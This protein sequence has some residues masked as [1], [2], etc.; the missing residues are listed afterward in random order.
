MKS[1]APV[2]GE[3]LIDQLILVEDED[4]AAPPSLAV[5]TGEHAAQL[6]QGVLVEIHGRG[7]VCSVGSAFHS[8]NAIA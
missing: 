2:C 7:S 6:G 4:V 3:L 1:S 8:S 5:E